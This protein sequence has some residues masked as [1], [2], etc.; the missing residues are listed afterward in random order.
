MN[1][2]VFKVASPG[3]GKTKWLLNIANMYQNEGRQVYLLAQDETEY[4]KFC[5][6][7][8]KTYSEVCHVQRLTAVKDTHNSVVLID[9]LLNHSFSAKDAEYINNNCYKMFVTIAGTT[10]FNITE[11]GSKYE[12]LSFNFAEVAASA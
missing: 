6:K 11:N 1:D 12:Q 4:A 7:Y 2:I 8:F 9:N 10:E 3:E 5:E